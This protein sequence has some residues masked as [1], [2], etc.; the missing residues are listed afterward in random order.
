MTRAKTA[1]L[2]LLLALAAVLGWTPSGRA[3]A[4]GQGETIDFIGIDM[5]IASAAP[6]TPSSVSTVERC[7]LTTTLD[8]AAGDEMEVDVV[9]GSSAEGFVGI[10]GPRGLSGFDFFVTFDPAVVDFVD[11]DT[12]G[13]MIGVADGSSQGDIG[14][15]PTGTPG[16][17]HLVGFD[18]TANTETG[19]GVLARLTLKAVGKGVSDLVLMFLDP[20]DLQRKEGALLAIG[21]PLT[22]ETEALE[23]KV[24]PPN[25][26]RSVI[27]V[28]E[29]C[30]ADAGTPRAGEGT[31]S[32][33]PDG[34]PGPNELPSTG[35][36]SGGNTVAI[37]IVVVGVVAL[38]AGGAYLYLRGRGRGEGGTA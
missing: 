15:G 20:T 38:V 34:S 32:G 11:W 16:E 27:A 4:Q 12:A 33:G 10:P 19:E 2:I 36:D 7:N 9:V 3:T 30:P 6:N 13:Q 23:T 8:P 26:G 1:L 29:D 22:E 28:A 21:D 25:A 5:E 31:P 17:F 18:T 35:G 37:V 14:T 24:L